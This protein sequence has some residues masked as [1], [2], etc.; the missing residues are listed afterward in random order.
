MSDAAAAIEQRRRDDVD[1]SKLAHLMMRL[2]VARPEELFPNGHGPVPPLV[3]RSATI[4]PR[5]TWLEWLG[6]RTHPHFRVQQVPTA[7]AGQQRRRAPPQELALKPSAPAAVPKPVVESAR[8]P[9]IA[10]PP[11][12]PIAPLVDAD[13]SSDAAA[14]VNPPEFSPEKL[15]PAV[16]EKRALLLEADEMIHT[17]MLTIER[18]RRKYLS[19]SDDDPCADEIQEVGKCYHFIERQQANAARARDN[20]ASLA[21]S[22]LRCG[23]YVE[24]LE[25]CAAQ[26][27]QKHI[28]QVDA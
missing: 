1:R 21:R 16:A 12:A 19:A 3:E 7:P 28:A 27:A 5:L 22:T 24:R 14:L 18:A 17:G 15:C 10:T 6:V 2:G 26:L 8:A 9:E 20:S 13:D 11:P 4:S 23:P 25:K